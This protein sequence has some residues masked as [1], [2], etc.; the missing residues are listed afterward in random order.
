MNQQPLKQNKQLPKKIIVQRTTYA[1]IPQQIKYYDINQKLESKVSQGAAEIVHIAKELAAKNR[2]LKKA[3]K[4]LEN[5]AY[6]VSHDL[7]EPLR[8]INMFTQ[9]LE[10]EYAAKLDGQAQEYMSYITGSAMRMQTMI[11][12]VLDYS[13]AGKNEQNWQNV[14][15]NQ[16]V[17]TILIDLQATIQETEAKIII[18]HL[19]I[20]LVKPTAISQLLRNLISNSIKFRSNQKPHIEIASQLQDNQWLIT[21]KDNGMGIESEYQDKIFQAFKRLHSQE[22]Y[23]GNG[24]GL[25]ICQKIVECHQGYIGVQSQLGKGSTFYFTLPLTY[26]S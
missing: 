6:T 13:R 20:V 18:S 21:V 3:N 14:D 4:Q 1:Q 12:D 26:H 8:S 7:Q 15:L 11:R 19:P 25:A 22:Q 5:F 17:A 9:L 16:L 24:I 10:K 2:E 23:S